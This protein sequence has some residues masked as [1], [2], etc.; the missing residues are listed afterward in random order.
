MKKL[1]WKFTHK[2]QDN[3]EQ[4]VNYFAHKSPENSDLP[5]FMVEH[6]K[7]VP[8][9]SRKLFRR[10]LTTAV[11]AVIFGLVACVTMIIVTPI[12][13][14]KLTKEE[15]KPT[16]IAFPEDTEE[17][18][19]AE[20]LYEYMQ[21]EQALAQ[22]NQEETEVIPEEGDVVLTE[23]QIEMIR[24]GFVMDKNNYR[25]IYGALS[26]YIREISKS[27]VTISAI[28]SDMDWLNTIETS[29]RQSSGVVI[30]QNG[31]ELLILADYSPL[32]KAE[33]LRVKFS[34]GAVILATLKGIEYD[35][36]LAVLS[37]SLF[38]VMACFK[39]E[40]LPIATLGTTGSVAVG[41]PVVAVGSPMGT[42]GSIGYGMITAL[43]TKVSQ[44]DAS[45]TML[46][47][48]IVGSSNASGVLFN[49]NGQVVG[50]IS[51]D[52]KQTDLGSL[53]SA[54]GISELKKRIE[55]ISNGQSQLFLGIRGTDVTQEANERLGVPFGAYV[56]STEMESPAMRAG[57][58]TGDIIAKMG[59][60][61]IS[62]FSDFSVLLQFHEP[63]DI[64]TL[65]IYRLSQ[66]EY[67]PIFMQV[68][69]EERTQ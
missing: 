31:I 65:T 41:I 15:V 58:Q 49:L 67:K 57:I 4:K 54:Y 25:Q 27:V 7:K 2:K 34:N 43:K 40:V 59:D 12:L 24:A 47:T 56:T 38:D 42:A 22:E 21:Q 23:S 8:L 53:L 66:E 26:A 19:P 46:Q 68:Q 32:E 61:T 52:N 37:V 69:I 55:R 18:T 28:T 62:S 14:K 35:T 3:R 29:E 9:N 10:T 1:T 17:M 33:E 20:M 11:M 39:D 6:I 45:D 16:I 48:D 30:A 64:L 36:N 63:G 44:L 13:N 50:I 60:S 51:N 5:D